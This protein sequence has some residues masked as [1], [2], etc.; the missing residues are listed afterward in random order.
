MQHPQIIKA[1]DTAAPLEFF[2]KN[3]F[4]AVGDKVFNHKIMA[5]QYATSSRQTMT[6]N[7]NDRDYSQINWRQ[8]LG[9]GLREIYRL[10]AQQLRS[11]YQYLILAWSGGGDSTQM[12]ESFLQNN[13][14][15]DEVVIIWPVSKTR[16]KYRAVAD[17]SSNNMI[18]EWDFSIKPKLDEILG[19]F[20]DLKITIADV[21]SDMT[22]REDADD[23]VLITEKHS[24]ASI[25]RFRALD[26]IIEKRIEEHHNV[27]TVLGVGPAEMFVYDNWLA[28]QFTDVATN[29]G[30]KS[31]YTLRGWPRNMEFFYWTPDFPEIPREQAHAM[32]DHLKC[33]PSD[34]KKLPRLVLDK[35]RTFKV[36]HSPPHEP[37]RNLYKS[38]I[39]PD[40]NTNTFQVVKPTDTHMYHTNYE[41]FHRDP[42]SREFT[43]PWESAVRAHQALISPEFFKMH[44]GRV[45]GYSVLTSKPYIVDRFPPTEMIDKVLHELSDKPITST[46]YRST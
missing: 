18:S 19:R 33:F 29:P 35:D 3:G 15:V 38:V 37:Y 16:G 32:M 11:K 46:W 41:W 12:L 42:H 9:V 34:I 17:T 6:W 28:V 22:A 45:V 7:F 23:T 4:Y 25:Q 2:K 39:Y 27:A 24:F 36:T 26:A 14:P 40:Y 31:D 5:M 10:R 1:E 13:I 30:S 43:E 8:R 20:P 21:F 44:D